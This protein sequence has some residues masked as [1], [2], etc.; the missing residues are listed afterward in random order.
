[1]IVAAFTHER[2]RHD[3]PHR[4]T[5]FLVMN[6]TH[7][8]RSWRA[9][10]PVRFYRNGRDLDRAFQRELLAGLQRRNVAAVLDAKGRVQL[11]FVSEPACRR[12]SRARRTIE[13]ALS[14]PPESMATLRHEQTKAALLNDRLRPRKKTLDR[15]KPFDR[16]LTAAELNALL[17]QRPTPPKPAPK[18][19]DFNL[20][21]SFLRSVLSCEPFPTPT[22]I[23]AAAIRTA[24]RN[25]TWPILRCI[26]TAQTLATYIRRPAKPVPRAI[27]ARARPERARPAAVPWADQL[28]QRQK[29]AALR[30]QQLAAQ[31]RATASRS[32][33]DQL[34]Q[35]QRIAA[36]RQQQ[37][38]AHPHAIAPRPRPSATTKQRPTAGARTRAGGAPIAVRAQQR[39]RSS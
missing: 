6:A 12:L 27:A 2:S 7:D 38:T 15:A 34:A 16:M 19:A 36:F 21:Q 35:R 24:Q 33:L 17:K 28:A 31:Q 14:N 32:R 4:H 3:D 5:H 13:R 39:S 25:I 23:F 11:P 26:D 22:R 9:L 1:M 30:Q 20:L 8:G 10:E 18:P 29:Q 37:P